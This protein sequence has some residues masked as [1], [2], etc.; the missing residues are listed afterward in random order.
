MLLPDRA[1]SMHKVVSPARLR[2]HHDL[3]ACLLV[4][5]IEQAAPQPAEYHIG[6]GRSRARPALT[7]AAPAG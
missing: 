4:D 7:A 1:A 5:P 3:A 2:A 6:G